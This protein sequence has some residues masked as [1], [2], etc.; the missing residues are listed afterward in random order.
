LLAPVPVLVQQAVRLPA[1]APVATL[2]AAE[3]R[4]AQVQRRSAAGLAAVQSSA[5]AR[6]TVAPRQSTAA[7]LPVAAQR[8]L[9]VAG[10][11]RPRSAIA[12]VA[13]PEAA[14]PPR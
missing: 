9:E 7:G 2:R 13:L 11:M 3:V 10:A 5:A 1:S 14:W 8:S 12:A 4:Q 6:E